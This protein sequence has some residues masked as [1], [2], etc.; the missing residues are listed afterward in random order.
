MVSLKS[1]SVDTILFVFLRSDTSTAASFH[2]FKLFGCS[3]LGCA[4]HKSKG[5]LPWTGSYL[6]LN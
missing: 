6:K 1:G 3:T 2:A 4:I 5:K